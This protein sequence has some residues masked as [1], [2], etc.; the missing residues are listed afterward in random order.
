MLPERSPNELQELM[1]ETQ[2]IA[3]G[4]RSETVLNA[5]RAVS[6]LDFVPDEIAACAFDDRALPI[7]N[8]Q[9]ISQPFIHAYMTDL[10]DVSPDHRILEVGTGSGY[11]T[12]L[13]AHLGAEVFTVERDPNLSK[14]ARDRLKTLKP[15]TI[16]F[17]IADGTLGWPQ[18]APFDRIIVT[19]AGPSIPNALIEQLKPDARLIMPVGGREQQRIIRLERRTGRTVERAFIPCRF[20]QLTGAQGW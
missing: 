20:V 17:L 15:G 13:L 5:M 7:E 12:A 16:H 8:G 1:I 4:I 2:I 18:K 19:A 14:T 6:R 10:L 11:Q 3:R 9:T